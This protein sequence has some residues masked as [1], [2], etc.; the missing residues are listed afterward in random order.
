VDT[1]LIEEYVLVKMGNYT[2]LSQ[3]GFNDDRIENSGI[4]KTRRWNIQIQRIQ[5]CPGS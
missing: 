2:V 5:S 4:L 3:P 1:Y